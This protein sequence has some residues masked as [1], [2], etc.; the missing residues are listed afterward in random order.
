M[1]PIEYLRWGPRGAA[2]WQVA[3]DAVPAGEVWLIQTCGIATNDPRLFSYRMQIVRA[4]H[5]HVLK[6]NETLQGSTPV[7]CVDRPVILLPGD[8]LV[9]RVNGAPADYGNGDGGTITD[10]GMALL[11]TGWKFPIADLPKLLFGGGSVTA[12]P[13]VDLT[14]FVAQCH[15]AASALVSIQNPV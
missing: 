3:G 12:A 11:Y 14:E 6:V 10:A 5:S 1:T 4:G 13:T 8:V 7:L 15:A 9:A 2:G